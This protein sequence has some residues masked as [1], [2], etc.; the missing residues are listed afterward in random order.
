M[1]LDCQSLNGGLEII[2]NLKP[3]PHKSFLEN[4]V[5]AFYFPQEELNSWLADHKVT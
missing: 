4:Y 2:T 3:L 1:L 5:K